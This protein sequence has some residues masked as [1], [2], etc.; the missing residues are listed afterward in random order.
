MSQDETGILYVVATPIGN[1]GDLS[2]R[3]AEVLAGAD[4]IAAEDTRH[5]QRLAETVGGMPGERLALYSAKEAERIPQVLERL[6]GGASVAL[7][8][9]AGTP[10]VSDPGGRLV[11]AAHEA[12]I[13]VRAVPGPSAVTAL[14]SAAGLPADRFCFRGFLPTQAKA[15]TAALRELAR[16]AETTVLFE[17]PRRVADLLAALAEHCG[18]DREAAVGR[19]LTKRYEAVHR[20]TLAELA[21]HFSEHTDEHRGELVLAVAG[22]L[23]AEEAEATLDTDRLLE[24]LLG[25]LPVSRAAKVAARASGGDRRGLYQRALELAGGD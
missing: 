6:R 14:L 20:A 22:R 13:A 11:A 3:A 16:R 7:V 17:S 23:E 4:L 9:D 24:A 12:G 21:A 19:E 15:R 10:A 25:E 5:I 1:R 18:G 2:P 8:S